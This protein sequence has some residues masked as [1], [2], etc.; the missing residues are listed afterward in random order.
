[1]TSRKKFICLF[2]QGI[3]NVV[4]VVN[5]KKLYISWSNPPGYGLKHLQMWWGKI[6][7]LKEMIICYLWKRV[8]IKWILLVYVDDMI[9]MGD[10]SEEIDRMKKTLAVEFELKEEV[11]LLHKY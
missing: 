5:W 7:T 9:V 2:L 11:K 3:R 1:M 10:D 4:G 6:T 8:T